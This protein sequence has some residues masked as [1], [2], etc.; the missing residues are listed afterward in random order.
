MNYLGLDL[1]TKAGIVVMN[2]ARRV[3]LAKE[4]SLPLK[5]DAKSQAYLERAFTIADEVLDVVHEYAPDVIVIEGYSFASPHSLATMVEI[6]TAVRMML[7]A[8][9]KSFILVPP[10]V[11]KK[12]VTGSGVGKKDEMKLGVFKRWG[13]EHKSDNVIDA[14]ALA[15]V[16]LATKNFLHSMNKTQLECMEKIERVDCN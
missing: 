7:K 11:L 9:E 2:D 13:Y 3:V 1:S 5:K 12:F 14:Y 8:S 4:L 6:G 15:C 10:T 16:A